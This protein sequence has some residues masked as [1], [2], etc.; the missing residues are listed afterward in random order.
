MN[1]V[2]L[3]EKYREELTPEQMMDIAEAIGRF[4]EYKASEKEM[5]RLC[6]IVY[7]VIGGGHFDKYFAD[8]AIGKIW[9][10][11]E[12]GK[13]HA[14]F[15]TDEE[16]RDVFKKHMDDISDYTIYD[17]A[18]T[19]NLLRSD[20]NGLL[21]KHTSTDDEMMDMLVDMVI[22]YLQDADTEYPTS[23]IWHSING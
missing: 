2:E 17:L 6:T 5:N 22:E 4:V 14:P 20:Y 16:V 13:H 7:G 11:D 18:V 19:M 1:Y 21:K 9:Y 15:F 3:I 10:E 12:D 8:E 23:K